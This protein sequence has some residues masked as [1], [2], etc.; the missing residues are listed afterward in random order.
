MILRQ[1]TFHL[2]Q[3][4]KTEYKVFNILCFLVHCIKINVVIKTY[5]AAK[6]LLFR[7]R[8][9]TLTIIGT[10]LLPIASPRH[11]HFM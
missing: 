6:L 1:N 11:E 3:V 10:L 9:A 7:R 8:E 2:F 5:Q 4:G